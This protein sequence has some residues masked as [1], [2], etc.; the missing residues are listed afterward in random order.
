[1]V[2]PGEAADRSG[3]RT[4][5]GWAAL[6]A[7]MAVCAGP[8]AFA[9]TQPSQEPSPAPSA[10]PPSS[11]TPLTTAPSTPAAPA[12]AQAS[13]QN[14]VLLEAD[15]LVDDDAAH[16]ITA[17]GNVQIRY[18]GRT[19][20]A[21]QVVYD[22]NAGTVHATGDVEM[23]TEDGSVTY[24]DE[25]ETDDSMNVAIATELRARIGRSGTLA[26]RAALRHG[27]G[28]TELE[29]VIYTSCPVCEGGNRP[30]TWSLRA[31]RAIQNRGART[32]TYQGAVLDV[33]GVPVLYLPFFGHPDPTVGRASGFLTPKLGSNRRLGAYYDQ[34]YYWAISPSQ[35]LTASLRWHENINPLLGV[36]YRQRF[37]SGQLNLETTFTDEQVFDTNGVRSGPEKFRWSAFG[38]GRFHINDYWDW[39]FGLEHTYDNYYLRRYDL[40]QITGLDRGPYLGNRTRLISQLYAVGQNETSYTSVSFVGFQGLRPTDTS[41]L[42]PV[43]APFAQTDQV[44]DDP[45]LHGQ[46]RFQANSAVLLRDN[47]VITTGNDGRVSASLDWRKDMIVGPGLVLSPFAQARGDFFDIETTPDHYTTITRGL[48]LAGAQISWP[49]MRP[50]ENFD[51]VVEPVAMAAYGSQSKPDPRIVNEDALSFDLDESN[52]F[53]PNAAPNY[54]LWE[55]GAREA[56]GVRATARLHTGESA[57]LIFGRRFRDQNDPQFTA[58]ENLSGTASDY[59]AGVQTDLGHAFGASASVRLGDE[60]LNVERVDLALR[61][62][63]GRFTV[64]AHYFNLNTSVYTT[65]APSEELTADVGI[66][67]VRGWRAQFGLVRDLDSDIN[68]RQEIAAIYEDDCTFLE[69]A[70]SRTETQAGTI[71]PNEGIQ[72][73]FGLRSLGVFGGS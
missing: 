70:Y 67:L 11:P 6:A 25:I 55:P 45:L 42:L 19:L 22:L 12:P 41:D 34:P 65:A 47:Q 33:V 54:D 3:E 18:Q 48:G 68:L 31:R 63:A 73:R 1:M 53:R 13:P 57:S 32:I 5:F 72:I 26:A 7:A 62:A 56:V 71:G 69:I 8:A 60:S 40:Q 52:L 20:R 50:G 66:E 14:P 35:D 2:R 49:F 46:L 27:P 59:V 9:Q 61:A 15:Q 64:Q 4:P 36:N 28:E 16:T 44:F 38:D 51:L 58:A 24:A 29:N 10:A 43:I 21:N 37:F 23:M 30:P 39:G 17:Q